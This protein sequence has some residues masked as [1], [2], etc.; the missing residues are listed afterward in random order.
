MANT[1]SERLELA[2]LRAA[3]EFKGDWQDVA[4][5]LAV[6]DGTTIEYEVQGTGEPV[7]FVHGALIA[8]GFRPLLLEPALGSSYSLITYRRRGYGQS[9]DVP[10]SVRAQA[11]DC[12]ALLRHLGIAQAHVV[13]HSFGG[14]VAIQLAMDAPD[15]V[16]SL[17]LLEPALFGA[18][19]GAAYRDALARGEQRYKETSAEVVTNEFLEMRF[20]PGYRGPLEEMLPG[21]FEEAVSNAQATF[22][23]DLPV[24][25]TWDFDEEKARRLT[26]PVLDVLGSE[27][28]ALWPRFG[29]VYR[30]VLSWLPHAE[31]FVLPGSAHSLSIQN[32]GGMAEALADF[33]KRHPIED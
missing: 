9:S 18:D 20:G 16:H 6:V 25:R 12:R 4:L 29:E 31:G 15:I 21:A 7:I 22:E 33:L 28:E 1:L 14:A 32:P 26:L 24:L 23:M 10:G 2:I 17:A 8:N 5:S 30:M 19:S 3:Q 27:S 11:S 13:G